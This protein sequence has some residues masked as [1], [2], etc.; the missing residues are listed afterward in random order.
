MVSELRFSVF[1]FPACSA[2]PRVTQCVCLSGLT[3]DQCH[4]WCQAIGRT[5]I[6]G[7][8]RLQSNEERIK[9][10]RSQ[11]NGCSKY[12][13]IWSS[14]TV[15]VCQIIGWG[16]LKNHSKTEETVYFPPIQKKKNHKRCRGKGLSDAFTKTYNNSSASQK[17]IFLTSK[18]AN[19]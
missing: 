2:P 11:L 5:L 7:W 19:L 8:N 14:Q 10:L 13:G 15:Y 6:S 9:R 18:E 4:N 12:K 3:F 1:H 16:G 17:F